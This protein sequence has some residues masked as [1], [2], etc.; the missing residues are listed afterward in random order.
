MQLTALY[1]LPDHEVVAALLPAVA[2][3]HLTDAQARARVADCQGLVP[4]A[5]DHANARVLWADLGAHP[6]REWQFLYTLEKLAKDGAVGEC[7]ASDA[8]LLADEAIARDGIMP[9]GFI[10]HVSRC[11]STLL[12]KSLARLPAHVV[13]NQGGPLQRGFWALATDDWRRPL[14]PTPTHLRMF[15]NLVLAMTR[16]RAAG[17]NRAFVKFISWNI[18]YA[19]FVMQA[20]PGVP[21]LFLYREPV[22]VI[23]SVMKETT[24]A[25][26]AKPTRQAGFLIAGDWRKAAAMGDIEYLAR[27][28]ANYFRTALAIADARLHYLNYTAITRDNLA[29]ILRKGLH[30][31]P[32]EA[33]LAAM[34]EQFRYHSKD[35][36]DRQS[37]RPD[38]AQKQAAMADADRRLVGEICKGLIEKLDNAQRNLFA[39]QAL[40]V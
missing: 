18:L 17:Q 13:V 11:G 34:L 29:A 31:D 32:A 40:S 8:S 22:E 27:C 2:T 24:A 23:A 21:C 37:F 10:F 14:E 36:S 35:D 1:A 30:F 3:R 20:F 28:Y 9:S 4:V 25:L 16:R 33:D 39:A 26:V 6:Y 7:F 12:A 38:S 5:I 15:R 19:S